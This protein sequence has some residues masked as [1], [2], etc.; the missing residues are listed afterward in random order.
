MILL[1]TELLDAFSEK[2]EDYALDIQPHHL[3]EDIGFNRAT[4]AWSNDSDGSVTP[5]KRSFLLKIDDELK[6]KRGGINLVIGPT[7]SGKTSLLMAL[8]G[9]CLRAILV[10]GRVTSVLFEG[11]MHFIANSPD[12]WYNLPRGGG[13]AYAAQES[14]VQNETIRVCTFSLH[15]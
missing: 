3:S 1:Q 8:L 6:F 7:G 2:K 12:S 10:D 15:S 13:V 9:K 4:F 14:W 11:E 5:S